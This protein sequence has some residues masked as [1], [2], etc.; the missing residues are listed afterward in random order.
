VQVQ[1]Y[2]NKGFIMGDAI[3]REGQGGQAWL[4]YHLSPCEMVQA[5]FRHNK[6]ADDFIPGGTTQNSFDMHIVKRFHE[7]VELSAEVQREWWKAPVYQ[8]GEKTDTVATFQLT[9]YPQ[10][11]MPLRKTP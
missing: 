6:V 4:T 5:S 2:T 10:R 3:G 8:L 7:N 11:G 1:G 9:I